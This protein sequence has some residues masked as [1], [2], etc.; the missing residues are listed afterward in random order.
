MNPARPRAAPLAGT[1]GVYR[2]AGS[3]QDRG[4][5]LGRLLPAG[6]PNAINAIC[7]RGVRYARTVTYEPV[8][9]LSGKDFQLLRVSSADE[10]R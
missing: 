8:T 5:R 2:F 7:S 9:K 6:I 3:Q 10:R 1:N 4:I